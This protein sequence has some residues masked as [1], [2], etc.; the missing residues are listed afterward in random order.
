MC[1]AGHSLDAEQISL[2]YDET[3]G[4]P[5]FVIETIRAGFVAAS[6]SQADTR[7]SPSIRGVRAT[8]RGQLPPKVHAVIAARLAQLSES[9]R[10]LVRLAATIG[11]SFTLDL[12]AEAC[13]GDSDSLVGPLDELWQRHIVREQGPLNYDFSHDKIREVAYTEMSAARRAAQHRR[14]AQALE[15]I[16]AAD[17]DRVSAQV[18]THYAQGDSPALAVPYYRRG[19]ELA[20][21]V[22]AHFDAIHLLD[23]GLGLLLSLPPSQAR[24]HQELAMQTALGTS[25]V[26]TK[27]YGAPEVMRTYRRARELCQ[28]LGKPPSPPVLRALAIAS[29]AHADFEQAHSLGDHL[30]TLAALD[31]DP[32]LLVE[33]NYVL[34]VASFWKGSFASSRVYLEEALRRYAPAQLPA[35]LSL[36]AQDPR[37]VC[38]SRLALDLWLL[39]Y[40]EQ[41][42]PMMDSALETAREL[43]HP[44]SLGYAQLFAMILGALQHDAPATAH[45]AEASLVLSRQHEMTLWLTT[46]TI[47]RGWARAET[48]DIATG[49][50]EMRTGI[51]AFR[52]GG[53]AYIVPFFLGLLA[54]HYARLARLERALSVNS[55]ALAAVERTGERWYGAELYRSRGVILA[56]R[57]DEVGAELALR[58]AL[59]IARYQEAKPFELRAA[60]CLAQLS[61]MSG[62]GR[63]TLS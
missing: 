26:A 15:R 37:V 11:R 12:L 41:A 1:V 29:I 9:A 4:Q 22:H 6:Q 42:T 2:L 30:L 50:A 44:F 34:G 63:I 55:E 62:A 10:Q 23:K 47:L 49:L 36:Y 54:Q 5:L 27:A 35:H 31:N 19:A 20:Q 7:S 40:P 32:V 45:H 3:E 60:D 18:A 8:E 25:L 56:A 53:N 46:A 16:A 61:S 38:M 17:L 43:S 48:S 21:R 33:G 57:G 51:R 58:R 13:D 24:D 39:G 28:Q 52:A 14:V 59:E